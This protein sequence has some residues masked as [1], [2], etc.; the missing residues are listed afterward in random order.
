MT[1]PTNPVI[2]AAQMLMTLAVKKI[3]VD[4]TPGNAWT[5]RT[6]RKIIR[7]GVDGTI[8]GNIGHSCGISE[9]SSPSLILIIVTTAPP[10]VLNMSPDIDK[11]RQSATPDFRKYNKLDTSIDRQ[12]TNNLVAPPIFTEVIGEKLSN[13]SIQ[14]FYMRCWMN[15]VEFPPISQ[16]PN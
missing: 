10:C 2:L 15:L 11:I 7:M 12:F 13:S 5:N 14:D 16:H 6:P 8:P 3:F 4:A 9:T 1:P